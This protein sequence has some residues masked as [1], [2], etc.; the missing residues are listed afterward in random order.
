MAS[1]AA[2]DCLPAWAEQD[3]VC[4]GFTGPSAVKQLLYQ[5]SATAAVRGHLSAGALVGLVTHSTAQVCGEHQG[6]GAD[7]RRVLGHGQGRG[8]YP[9]CARRRHAQGWAG[10]F[11][12]HVQRRA[13]VLPHQDLASL[14]PEGQPEPEEVRCLPL[15]M[16]NMLTAELLLTPWE[17]T[18]TRDLSAAARRHA[19]PCRFAV[20]SALA[21]SA[22][23]SLVMARG[24]R[25]ESVPELP[26]GV[27]SAAESISKT[28]AALELLK[29]VGA[30]EDAAK[31][32]A[33]RN[34]RRGKGKILNRCRLLAWSSCCCW[35][36]A[37]A[38]IMFHHADQA[39]AVSELQ[40]QQTQPDLHSSEW[41]ACDATKLM[42]LTLPCPA[43]RYTNRKGPLIV[44][45]QDHGISKAFRNLP[46]VD[47]LPVTALNLL[48]VSPRRLVS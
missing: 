8:P 41:Q 16:F 46:G 1:G 20:A 38:L 40:Y 6:W 21:A 33:S 10:R 23:P 47:V 19:F 45:D 9:P 42:L 4:T 32:K 2:H 15:L 37:T 28:K 3:W 35:L 26:L 11:R 34:I 44:Y 12:Q 22:L 17:P 43:R 18:C 5:Q 14:A 24:H 36:Q 13:H 29:S 31:A 30:I 27:G 48:D 39:P 25:I 7:Q